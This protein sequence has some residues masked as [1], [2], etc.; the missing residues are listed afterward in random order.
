MSLHS[1]YHGSDTRS[2]VINSNDPVKWVCITGPT[3]EEMINIC[4]QAN[5]FIL[6]FY[7]SKY[8]QIKNA[9]KN[10]ATSRSLQYQLVHLFGT[11]CWEYNVE[12]DLIG[13]DF[14]DG[15]WSA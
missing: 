10:L 1:K 5:L 11:P 15:E 9:L 3:S 12:M 6:I 2:Q 14:M 8:T 13:C 7:L 4:H